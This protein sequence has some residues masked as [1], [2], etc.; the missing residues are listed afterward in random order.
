MKLSVKFHTVKWRVSTD[1]N[2]EQSG[3]TFFDLVPVCLKPEEDKGE[4]ERAKG[5][6]ESVGGAAFP[7]G[8]WR[9]QRALSSL[10]HATGRG[11]PGGKGR[12]GETTGI[13]C[14][15]TE[16]ALGSSCSHRRPLKGSVVR[17]GEGQGLVRA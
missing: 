16:S 15:A 3:K 5:G 2:A 13:T 9:S 10:S 6:G 4:G 14:R 11:G 8:A 1:L 17:A 7:R 12:A